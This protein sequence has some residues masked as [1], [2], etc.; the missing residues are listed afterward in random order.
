MVGLER[1]HPQESPACDAPN[2]NEGR[3]RSWDLARLWKHGYEWHGG[4]TTIPNQSA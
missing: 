1:N 4:S 2:Q 3:R